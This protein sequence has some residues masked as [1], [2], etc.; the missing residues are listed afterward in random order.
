MEHAIMCPQCNAPLV[1][2]P[3]ASTVIC[4]YCGATVQLDES[5]VS[6]T[7]FHQ[8]FHVWNSPQTYG[9]PS[10][11]SLGESHWA[12]DHLI[13]KGEISDVYFGQRARWPTELVVVKILRD[14]QDSRQLDNEWESL[15]RLHGSTTQGAETFT[16]MLPQ[17]VKHSLI[18]AGQFAGNQVSIF[19]W[20]SGFRHTLAEVIQAYPKGIP[21]RIS[22]WVWRRILEILFF[23]HASGMAHG[24]VLPSHLLVQDNEHGIRLIGYSF[25]GQQ[26]QKIK[27]FSPE[28]ESIDPDL[29]R[30]EVALAPQLDLKMSARCIIAV[31]GGEPATASLPATVP[32]PLAELIKRIALI[33]LDTTSG[34]DAWSI[35]EEL[36]RIADRVF[37]PPRFCPIMLPS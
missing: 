22:I 16:T 9:F 21:P 25:A 11:I 31:L 1:V 8:A 23:I 35:R 13:A 27:A 18:S 3:F 5:S 19:R 30:A 2:H 14:P 33:D 24:A 36:G 10:W 34:E 20:E 37:G 29:S 17:L 4:S 26:G 28:S 12:I 32:S 15:E 6:A 7:L